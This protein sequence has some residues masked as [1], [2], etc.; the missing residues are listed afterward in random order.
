MKEQTR[1]R[2]ATCVVLKRVG[3]TRGR[4][5]EWDD[6]GEPSDSEGWRLITERGERSSSVGGAGGEVMMCDV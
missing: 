2:A 3:R 1:E 4:R 6:G 5:C